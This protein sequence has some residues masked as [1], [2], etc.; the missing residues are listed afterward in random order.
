LADP[1]NEQKRLSAAVGYVFT[2]VVPLVLMSGETK[3]DPFLRRHASQALIWSIGLLIGLTLCV[4]LAI[5]LIRVNIW[6]I[7]LLPL[8][9]VVPFIPGVAWAWKVYNGRDVRIP[10][11]TPLAERL[12]PAR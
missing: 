12:F 7:F 1:L 11:I 2:P 8:V 6:M 5:A 3:D 9:F 4:I 10:G